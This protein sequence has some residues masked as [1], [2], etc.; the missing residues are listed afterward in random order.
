MDLENKI[1]KLNN[2]SRS[3]ETSVHVY[4]NNEIVQL[5]NIM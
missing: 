3:H 1:E 2:I 4:E 5:Y